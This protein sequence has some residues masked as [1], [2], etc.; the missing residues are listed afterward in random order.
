[1]NP[2]LMRRLR[3]VP[4]WCVV[5]ILRQ[6]NVAEHS[7]HVAWLSLWLLDRIPVPV[8]LETRHKVLVQALVHDQN[9]AV[10]GDIPSPSKSSGAVTD[11]MAYPHHV[12]N[13]FMRALIKTADCLEA[14]TF[15]YEEAFMGNMSVMGELIED[16]E[17][18]GER[19]ASKIGLD[20]EQLS[21]E[22]WQ[23]VSI[24]RHP[25]MDHRRGQA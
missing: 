13:D 3:F 15:L 20:F 22:L 19:W 18:N 21:D 16:V 6:Q 5:P 1:M 2:K 17:A 24:G 12:E 7:F 25:A 8:S 9:E 11:G 23:L 4:R 10:T 14:A